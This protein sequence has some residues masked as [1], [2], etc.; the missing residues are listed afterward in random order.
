MISNK[1]F[2]FKNEEECEYRFI[3]RYL[4]NII[5]KIFTLLSL[6]KEELKVVEICE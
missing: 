5:F 6:I 1:K 2:N 3:G 4:L